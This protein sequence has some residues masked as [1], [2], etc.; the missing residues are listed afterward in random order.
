MPS[1]NII[2][3]HPRVSPTRPRGARSTAVER[4]DGKNRPI[5]KPW[6]ARAKAKIHRLPTNAEVT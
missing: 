2:P 6:M 5:E 4:L 3:R 1:E